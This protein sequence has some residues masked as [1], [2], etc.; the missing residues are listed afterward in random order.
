[1]VVDSW[2]VEDI[3]NPTCKTENAPD[4]CAGLTPEQLQVCFILDVL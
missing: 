2:K 3:E 4:Y 1:M